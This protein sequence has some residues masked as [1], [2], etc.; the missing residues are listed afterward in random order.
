M[1]AAT[2]SLAEQW[3]D[4]LQVGTH[5]VYP[6]LWCHAILHAGLVHLFGDTHTVR[7]GDTAVAAAAGIRAFCVIIVVTRYT[8]L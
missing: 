6:S 2:L 5:R 1:R 7:S 3:I 4:N 8:S